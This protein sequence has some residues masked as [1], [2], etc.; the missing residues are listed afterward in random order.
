MPVDLGGGLIESCASASLGQIAAC[1]TPVLG[2]LCSLV[3]GLALLV[4]HEGKLPVPVTARDH[5]AEPTFADG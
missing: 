3:I 5:T 4:S 1:T 2:G